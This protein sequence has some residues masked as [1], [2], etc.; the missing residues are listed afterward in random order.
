M[1]TNPY[2]D[3]VR[4]E[5]EFVQIT[6]SIAE[7]ANKL[8]DYDYF[9][10]KCILDVLELMLSKSPDYVN[11]YSNNQNNQDNITV[12]LEIKE[13]VDAIISEVQKTLLEEK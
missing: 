11:A 8:K 7:L 3:G 1:S 2:D 12:P 6:S 9:T 5:E 13:D 4:T 10:G